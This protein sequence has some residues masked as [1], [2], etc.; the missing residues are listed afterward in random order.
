MHSRL[1]GFNLFKSLVHGDS[2]GLFLEWVNEDL[3][4]SLPAPFVLAQGNM[5]ISK[6][7]V[8][9]GMHF[10]TLPQTKILICA[11]GTIQDYA[12]DLR[13][14]SP[15]FGKSDSFTLDSKSRDTVVIDPGLAHGF[16]VLSEDATLIYLTNL[17]YSPETDYAL[18]VFDSEIEISI[19]HANPIIS[20]RDLSAPSLQ[21]L[22][23]D[24]IIDEIQQVRDFRSG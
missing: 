15:S 24:G 10:S 11:H 20:E 5:S 22:L 23:G 16:E 1:V 2:R 17:K 8:V 12:V 7:G 6:F 3:L 9:R 18:N 14:N 4:N 13:L 19:G 21:K